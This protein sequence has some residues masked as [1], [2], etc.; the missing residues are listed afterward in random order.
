MENV[1]YWSKFLAAIGLVACITGA[2]TLYFIIYPVN[3][4]RRTAHITFAHHTPVHG[5]ESGSVVLYL[6]RPVGTV[7]SIELRNDQ[8]SATLT[9]NTQFTINQST[10]ATIEITDVSCRKNIMVYTPNLHAPSIDS[11]DAPVALELRG[12]PTSVA[13][14]QQDALNIMRKVEGILTEIESILK[15]T[16]LE[17]ANTTTKTM[18][19][20]GD[21]RAAAVKLQAILSHASK[22][23]F[24]RL[25]GIRNINLDRSVSK[26][27]EVHTKVKRTST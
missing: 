26:K 13:N 19:T 14:L 10:Y 1:S 23:M 24:G 5:L 9:F 11:G 15:D 21:I 12:S 3:K 2:V 16:R 6:G 7:S 17:V 22:S 18:Q 20:M 4:I 27:K 8:I 25:I